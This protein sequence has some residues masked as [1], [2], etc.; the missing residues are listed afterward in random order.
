MWHA[1]RASNFAG[2]NRV[3]ID[4][5]VIP[6]LLNARYYELA[7]GQFI[8]Q[9]PV[10]WEVG[11][12]QDGKLALTNP[13]AINSYGYANDNPISTKDP[14]GRCGEPITAAICAAVGALFIP[15]VAGDPV[16]NADGTVSAT[17]QQASLEASLFI[18]GFA[19]PGGSAKNIGNAAKYSP[20]VIAQVERILGP[21]YAKMLAQGGERAVLLE[22]SAN[23]EVKKL[24]NELYRAKDQIPGGTAGAAI[25]TKI[26]QQLVGNSTHIGKITNSLNRIGN[27]LNSLGSNLSAGD[28][29]TVNYIGSQLQK[30]EA[31][32]KSI[33]LGN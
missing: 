8:S 1:L 21:Q 22:Q 30:A 3:E 5:G 9:D 25:Y 11:L 16:F 18:G 15:Q 24:I 26:S 32:I 7:R 12:T 14:N 27:I 31:M 33:K 6:A 23:D 28:R 29:Q 4:A 19:I 13:Q 10:F 17:P 2:R 20:E